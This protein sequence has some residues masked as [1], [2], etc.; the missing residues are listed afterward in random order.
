M[1]SESS[2]DLDFNGNYISNGIQ[3]SEE[4]DINEFERNFDYIC[5]L[6]QEKSNLI[7]EYSDATGVDWA[8]RC[9]EEESTQY[10]LSTGIPGFEEKVLPAILDGN[11]LTAELIG[12]RKPGEID[13]YLNFG[14]LELSAIDMLL[15]F[16]CPLCAVL[17]VLVSFA[18]K[19]DKEIKANSLSIR[20]H[21]LYVLKT[22]FSKV[23]LGISLGFIVSLFFIGAID[24][25]ITSV[26]RIFVLTILLGYQAHAFWFIQEEYL[27]KYI[28]KKVKDMKID[29]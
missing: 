15:I 2:L 22:I 25:K 18:A 13:V 23:F 10:P 16:G 4:F 5:G 1:S 3:Q 11:G 26:T 19:N 7:D 20:S 29:L 27:K 8:A 24:N 17:G 28:E 6:V 9:G 12:Y 14:G 21:V